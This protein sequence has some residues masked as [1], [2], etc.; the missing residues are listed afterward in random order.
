MRLN[1]IPATDAELD[2][3]YGVAPTQAEINSAIGRH[4]AAFDNDD[5]ADILFEHGDKILIDLANSYS[6]SVG[7]RIYEARKETIA[8]RAS[9][10]LYGKPDV[11]KP[12]QVE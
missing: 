10:E 12:F 11:I 4:A 8:R 5:L 3:F 7:D 9:I 6:W 1:D 2:G